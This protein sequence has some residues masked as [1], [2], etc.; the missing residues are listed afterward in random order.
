MG[1][2]RAAGGAAAVAA[3]RSDARAARTGTV[4]NVGVALLAAWDDP[5][6]P[7]SVMANCYTETAAEEDPPADAQTCAA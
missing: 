1:A 7:F 5:W 6:D 2:V 3:R 4:A